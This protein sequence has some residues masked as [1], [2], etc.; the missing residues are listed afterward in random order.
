MDL[1]SV[2]GA[3]LGGGKSANQNSANNQAG[4]DL[5]AILKQISAASGNNNAAANGNGIDMGAILKQM[6][7]NNSSDLIN[8]IL[9]QVVAGGLGKMMGNASA[10]ASQANNGL[11]NMSNNDIASAAQNAAVIL[12]SILGSK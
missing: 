12:K 11:G 6:A 10:N 8:V 7:G 5:G 1:T 2:L 4:I 3:V 9:K